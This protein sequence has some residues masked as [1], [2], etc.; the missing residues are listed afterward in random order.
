MNRLS[1]SRIFV[2]L[3]L[4]LVMPAAGAAGQDIERRPMLAGKAYQVDYT[5][6]LPDG[7]VLCTTDSRYLKKERFEE[8]ARTLFVPSSAYEP[9]LI[10]I[11]GPRELK[12]GPVP[13][14][15]EVEYRLGLLLAGQM[16]GDTLDIEL[17]SE[18]L[19]EMSKEERYLVL[20]RVMKRPKLQEMERA[21]FVQY[22]KKEPRPGDVLFAERKHGWP[23]EVL[24]VD[25]QNV[26]IRYRLAEGD[27]VQMP[28]GPYGVVRDA[29]DKWEIILDLELGDLVRAGNFIGQISHFDEVAFLSD[30]G[31]PFG[32]KPLSCE[33]RAKPLSQD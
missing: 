3:L 22:T 26:T 2:A 16:T 4:A 29:G 5:C 27:R 24:S 32:G 33:V 23:W 15:E 20:V 8:T 10:T 28:M 17:T 13:L 21:K 6:R 12:P 14:I 25:E 7:R 19:E 31:H 1:S 30:F 9:A 18:T 11:E